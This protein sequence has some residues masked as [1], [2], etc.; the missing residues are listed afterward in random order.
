MM[1]EK[2]E[3]RFD[4]EKAYPINQEAMSFFPLP[5]ALPPISRLEKANPK[6]DEI[7]HQITI[8]DMT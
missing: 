6:L 2:D 4:N 8:K 5:T 1:C 3:G 7:D